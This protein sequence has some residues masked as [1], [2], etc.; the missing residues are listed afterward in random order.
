MS[1]LAIGKTYKVEDGKYSFY[2]IYEGRLA[3]G[4]PNCSDYIGLI[5]L[6]IDDYTSGS[7]KK[8][9]DA[10]LVGKLPQIGFGNRLYTCTMRWKV[11]N[12][13]HSNHILVSDKEKTKLMLKGLI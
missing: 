9:N 3:S 10:G 2:F 5:V 6:N 1:R 11:F 7:L 13:Y 12:R 4:A 8:I